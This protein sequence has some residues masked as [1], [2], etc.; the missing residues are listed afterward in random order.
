MQLHDSSTPSKSNST[1]FFL[2]SSLPYTRGSFIKHVV[3]GLCQ[4]LADVPA[5]LLLPTFCKPN[6]VLRSKRSWNRVVISSN[7]TIL[8]GNGARTLVVIIGLGRKASVENSSSMSS[9]S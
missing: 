8:V 2:S 4:A 9:T 5:L 1:I 7:L 6:T 3:G